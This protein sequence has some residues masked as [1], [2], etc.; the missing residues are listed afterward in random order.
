ML[1]VRR[2]DN[3]IVPICVFHSGPVANLVLSRF[4]RDGAE[5]RQS[6][7]KGSLVNFLECRQTLFEEIREDAVS[8]LDG[9]QKR[10]L[11]VLVS[12]CFIDYWE[13]EDW[14]ELHAYEW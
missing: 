13:I 9:L 7:F 6:M 5:Q 11:L 14:E 4:L 1:N 2:I 12:I 10:Y 8:Q 3:S